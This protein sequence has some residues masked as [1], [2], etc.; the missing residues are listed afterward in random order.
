MKRS[1]GFT[2]IELLVV[3]AIIAILAAILFP[4]FARVREK[5][6]QTS[7]LSNEK[8]LGLALT[9]YVQ[10]NNERYPCGSAGVYQ[11][12][13]GW[14][15]T[16]YPYVKS[17]GAYTCPDDSTPG[18]HV[19]YN[20]NSNLAP[21]M[22]ENS[23]SANEI[24]PVK[25]SDFVAP[26]MSVVL[27]EAAYNEFCD[28]TATNPPENDSAVGNG[29]FRPYDNGVYDTGVLGNA[30][31]PGVYYQQVVTGCP[32][33][34]CWYNY[35]LADFFNNK[36][37]RHTGGS[38]FLYADGHAK[39]ANGVNIGAGSNNGTVGN[40]GTTNTIAPNSSCSTYSGTFSVY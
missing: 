36:I 7:C 19:S 39:W 15:G 20:L 24:I 6:R 22:W 34:G 17:A 4:V 23:K 9:Q 10:D 16:L 27:Y 31:D 28:V 2:L 26:A 35:T 30:T 40:C 5:A 25:V 32:G 21:S 8:Q 38:N 14:A 29:T 37:G 12:G 13:R 33:A 11:S 18:A 3:I 1:N